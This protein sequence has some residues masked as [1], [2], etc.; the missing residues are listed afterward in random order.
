MLIPLLKFSQR[1]REYKSWNYDQISKIVHTWLFTDHMGHRE[2]DK[3]IL[4]LDPLISKGWQ[5]MGVLHYL[6]LKKEFKGIFKNQDL[7]SA[8]NYLSDDQQDFNHIIELLENNIEGNKEKFINNFYEAQKKQDV[9]FESYYKLRLSELEKTD[10]GKSQSYSRKEQVILR[11]IL[12]KDK[13]EA[14][15]SICHKNL[16]VNLM[17][18]AHIKPRSKCNLNERKDS[19]IVMPVC[20]VGCDDYFEKGYITVD[21]N[22]FININKKMYLTS[23]LISLLKEIDG[24]KCTHFNKSTESFFKYKRESF[25]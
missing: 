9:Q 6:G 13:N 11:G 20:K 1:D 24:K 16:P 25:D 18:A 14:Q 15:C 17:V 8:I 23:E 7:N 2:M 22:G 19:N 10:G 21:N 4:D 12:F 5:S 3:E